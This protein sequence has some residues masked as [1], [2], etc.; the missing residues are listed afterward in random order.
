M[1]ADGLTFMFFSPEAGSLEVNSVSFPGRNR[2]PLI[3]VILALVF[4]PLSCS[5]IYMKNRSRDFADI[6]TLQVRT[7]S[8]GASLRAGPVKVGLQ[9]E[10]PAGS[11]LGLR[12]GEISDYY[13]AAFALLLIGADYIQETPIEFNL[14]SSSK[15][16]KNGPASIIPSPRQWRGKL[17][18]ARSP[19]GTQGD[20]QKRRNLLKGNK[21]NSEGSSDFLAPLSYY[22]DIQLSIGLYFGLRIGLN[23]GELLDFLLG[24]TTL[25]FMGDDGPYDPALKELKK[26]PFYRSL[27][28]PTRKKFL[29]EL[30]RQKGYSEPGTELP[31]QQEEPTHE[32][33]EENES[34]V[35]GSEGADQPLPPEEESRQQSGQ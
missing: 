19:F 4:F 8:Y 30:R 33:A 24:W 32:E 2:R 23:P 20:L 11:V 21:K 16:K 3:L 25:D 29:E 18:H 27:D 12:G 28:E 9:Y 10:S 15:T 6:F 31:Q 26:Y 34:E 5:S 7:Q 22:T 1:P 14:K 17:Y 13:E 35:T